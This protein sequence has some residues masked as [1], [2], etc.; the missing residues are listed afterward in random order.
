MKEQIEKLAEIL[1][2]QDGNTGDFKM[3]IQNQVWR[4]NNVRQYFEN[5]EEIINAGYRLPP[6]DINP[7]RL[8]LISDEDM[9][10]IERRNN[11][12]ADAVGMPRCGLSI[13]QEVAQAQLSHNLKE[14]KE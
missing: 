3:G 12:L 6:E 14:L 10:K 8:T 13:M 5:A 7:D 4:I 1:W 2:K 11:N 9:I